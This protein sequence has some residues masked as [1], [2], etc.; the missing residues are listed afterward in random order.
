MDEKPYKD[1]KYVQTNSVNLLCLIINKANGYYEEVNK[2]KYLTLIPTNESNE[3][4]K[5]YKELWSKIR[6][7]IKSRTKKSND[8]DKKH[9]KIKFT[10]NGDLS[11]IK[12]YKFITW[13]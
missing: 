12:R 5:K 2:N 7:L 1:S 10:L 13:Q 4:T 6:E 3:L 9:M 8:Y 11:L